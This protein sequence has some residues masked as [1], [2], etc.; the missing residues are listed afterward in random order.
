MSEEI[1]IRQPSAES[2]TYLDPQYRKDHLLVVLDCSK[3]APKYDEKAKCDKDHATFR[4]V[5]LDGECDVITFADNH[6]GIV[7]DINPGDVGVLIGRITTVQTKA[8]NDFYI[9]GEH[10]ADDVARFHAWYAKWKAGIPTGTQWKSP[11]PQTNGSTPTPSPS[12]PVPATATPTAAAT[13]VASGQLDLTKL[14]PTTLALILAQAQASA[15]Q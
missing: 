1:I 12:T 9:L 4:G 10:S 13:P 3:K 6:D 7:R 15:A 8:G 11:R 2:F 5:D 14:D